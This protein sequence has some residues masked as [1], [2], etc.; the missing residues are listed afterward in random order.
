LP[1]LGPARTGDSSTSYLSEDGT[2]TEPAG[3]SG[4]DPDGTTPQDAALFTERADHVNTP[5]AGL[6]EIWA[7]SE[8][9]SPLMYTNDDGVDGYVARIHNALTTNGIITSDGATGIVASESLLTFT[10]GE[11]K[12]DAAAAH[13]RLKEKGSPSAFTAGYGDVWTKNTAPSSLWF[14]D[15]TGGDFRV[16]TRLSKGVT[17]ADPA[18]SETIDLWIT[19]VAITITGISY[20]VRG[21][22]PSVAFDVSHGTDPDSLAVID[23]TGWTA[24]TTT[25]VNDSSFSGGDV[26][27]AA[28]SV[29]AA[30][31]GT[32]S[33]TDVFFHITVHYTE[34]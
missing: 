29:V 25:I 16:V 18:S 13:L 15:D 32:V 7:K 4:I 23:S 31:L 12:N 30:E 33:G 27:V 17:V 19:P 20:F 9:G 3:D 11:L 28:D 22:T 6:G 14:T 2:Y 34:D 24:T 5:A 1:G 10:G 21:T 26:T 8:A